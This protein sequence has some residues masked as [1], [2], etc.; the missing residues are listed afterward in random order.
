MGVSHMLRSIALIAC[1]VLMVASLEAEE[2][3]PADKLEK[4]LAVA[5]SLPRAAATGVY[6]SRDLLVEAVYQATNLSGGALRGEIVITGT[7][8]VSDDGIQYSAEPTDRLVVKLDG[9]THE[10]VI[11]EAQGSDQ[12][13]TATA[14]LDEPHMIRYSHKLEGEAEAEISVRF[15]TTRF[16]AEV[17]GWCRQFGMRYKVDLKSA[18]RTAAEGDFHGREEKT[19]YTLE[20]T[21]SGGG[22]EIAVSEKHTFE[23]ASATNLRLL[24]SQRGSASRFNVTI[25]NVLRFGGAEYSFKNVEIQFDTKTKGNETQ[26]GLTRAVGAVL[27]NGK[28]FGSCAVLVGK[29]VLKSPSGTV[30]LDLPL[31][32]NSAAHEDG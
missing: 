24:P 4:N 13:A 19:G 31:P 7:L 23:M 3:V 28:P 25:G 12:A 9:Q 10:F 8:R 22:A 16:S 26:S 27:R 18:G 2:E 17:K 29:A 14:W 32:G 1:A 20:G 30:V 5:F 15:E 11:K 21:I 6:Q